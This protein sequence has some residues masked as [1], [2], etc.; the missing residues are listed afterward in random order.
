MIDDTTTTD[1]LDAGCTGASTHGEGSDPARPTPAPRLRAE[2]VRLAYDD[3]VVVDD[4]S[5]D[6]PSGAIT[7]IVGPNACGKSTLLRALARLLTPKAGTVL[8]DGEQIRRMPTR[9][10]AQRL[11]ILPSNR[12]RPTGSPSPTWSVGAATR[13]SASSASGAPTTRPSSPRPW[14]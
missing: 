1:R 7:V 12:S 13:T 9:V 14:R 8:L 6:V 3:R 5:F 2:H 10:V 4:L 11:G